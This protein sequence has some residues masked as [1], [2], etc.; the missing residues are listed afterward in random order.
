MKKLWIG[1]GIVVVVALAIILIVTQTKEP[2]EIKIGAILPLTGDLAKF[3][4][5][6]KNGIDLAISEKLHNKKIGIIYEDDQGKPDIAVSAFR[7]L[8]NFHKVS[9]VI[10][11]IISSNAMAMAPIADKSKVVLLSPTATAPELTKFK[12][13]FRVQPSDLFEGKIMANFT[14][15]TLN[16]PKVAVVYVNNDWGKG[17]SDVFISEYRKVK[18]NI[19]AVEYFDRGAN[20]FRS[21]ISKV[22]WCPKLAKVCERKCR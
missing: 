17:L 16:N 18:G 11:G 20:D 1:I 7:K 15:R 6:F 3:G 10:G 8:I 2:K 22:R 13:F 9:L 14:F 4:V 21:I 19:V 12:F 5:S